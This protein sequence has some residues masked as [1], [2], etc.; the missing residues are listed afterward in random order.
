MSQIEFEII[1]LD[2]SN[3]VI[4]ILHDAKDVKVEKLSYEV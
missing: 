4:I 2:N 1:F 3:M